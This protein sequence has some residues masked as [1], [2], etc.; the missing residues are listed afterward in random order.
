M[1]AASARPAERVSPAG[2]W[3][4]RSAPPGVRAVARPAPSGSVG[5]PAAP[6]VMTQGPDREWSRWSGPLHSGRRVF[7]PVS[8]RQPRSPGCRL[9]S[10]GRCRCTRIADEAH[11]WDT[12]CGGGPALRI[13][14]A[15]S[16]LA[17][18]AAARGA[19][20]HPW[21]AAARRRWA[22]RSLGVPPPAVASGCRDDFRTHYGI[23][24]VRPHPAN[25]RA[26]CGAFDS[27]TPRS[28]SMEHEAA[29]RHEPH[30]R[31]VPPSAA[32]APSRGGAAGPRFPGACTA[33]SRVAPRHRREQPGVPG[34]CGRVVARGPL[35]RYWSMDSDS[36]LPSGSE[37]RT[38]P[39]I[40]PFTESRLR[41]ASARRLA[42]APV[43]AT[44]PGDAPSQLPTTPVLQGRRAVTW[45]LPP[46]AT[47]CPRLAGDRWPADAGAI[48]AGYDQ[49]LQADGTGR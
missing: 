9:G 20:S 24:V 13:R 11:A 49:A 15:T 46:P 14:R 3:T 26:K 16:S 48:C 12:G 47:G 27:R 37:R 36:L 40:C 31:I 45:G 30:D 38:T 10:P 7:P 44:R 22:T 33:K 28:S 32:G 18:A 1:P 5:D 43:L 25:E 6:Q 35:P 29:T 23:A 42:G 2:C 21:L 41:L 4:S 17:T 34:I 19:W 8:P 39:C